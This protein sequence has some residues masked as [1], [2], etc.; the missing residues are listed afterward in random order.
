MPQD[1]VKSSCYRLSDTI[2]PFQNTYLLLKLFV[3]YLLRPGTK[4]PIYKNI[5]KYMVLSNP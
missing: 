1:W 3:E 4:Q 2:V 5:K